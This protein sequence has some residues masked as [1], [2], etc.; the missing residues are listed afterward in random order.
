MINR[1]IVY[2]LTTATVG[3]TFF[4]GIVVLQAALRPLTGGSQV[5]VAASTLL[6]FALAQPVGRRVQS[7]VDRR[8]YRSRYDAARTIDAFS[9]Q[10]A[11]EVDLDAVGAELA[12]AVGTTMR[13]AHV[14]LWLRNGPGTPRG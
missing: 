11:G 2:G 7:W 6:C 12:A 10:L 13:P 4:A 9:L 3:I 14:S 8:F 1:A 5:A